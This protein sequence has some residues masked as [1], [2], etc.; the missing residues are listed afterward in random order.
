MTRWRWPRIAHPHSPLCRDQSA[1]DHDRA[2]QGL[3]DALARE[4]RN[5]GA[6]RGHHDYEEGSNDGR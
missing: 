5:Q 1:V 4:R 2:V 3:I 6:A